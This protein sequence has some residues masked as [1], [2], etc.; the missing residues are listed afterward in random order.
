ML[1]LEHSKDKSLDSS[2]PNLGLSTSTEQV[3]FFLSF[4]KISYKQEHKEK[5]KWKMKKTELGWIK[6]VI[7]DYML[8]DFLSQKNTPIQVL[9]SHSCTEV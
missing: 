5:R 4:F 9:I 3:F 2:L 8:Y 7:L 1:Q 6:I